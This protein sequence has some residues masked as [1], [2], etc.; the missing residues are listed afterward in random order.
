MNF[1]KGKKTYITGIA[2]VTY[3]VGGFYLGHLT[4]DQAIQVGGTGLGFIFLRGA[5]K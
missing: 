1:L 2:M 3:A 5:I 4:L